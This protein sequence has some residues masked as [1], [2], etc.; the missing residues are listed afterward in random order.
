MSRTHLFIFY[1]TG[2]HHEAESAKGSFPALIGEYLAE[3]DGYKIKFINGIGTEEPEPE[4]SLSGSWLSLTTLFAVAVFFFYNL[5]AKV[6][7]RGLDVIIQR[8]WLSTGSMEQGDKCILMG[9]S[10]GGFSA[11]MLAQYIHINGFCNAC[12]LHELAAATTTVSLEKDNRQI[13][14]LYALDPVG[15]HGFRNA[16][17]ALAQLSS[18]T[19]ATFKINTRILNATDPPMNVKHVHV[20]LMLDECRPPFEP[21]IY[22]I[23]TTT[24]TNLAP[25]IEQVWFKGVHADA[26]GPSRNTIH[27]LAYILASFHMQGIDINVKNL[28]DARQLQEW[29]NAPVSRPYPWA[30]HLLSIVGHSRT[31]IH[32]PGTSLHASAII[33]GETGQIRHIT[34]KEE[35]FLTEINNLLH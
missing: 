10:R 12:T 30:G 21:N 2:D 5:F 20:V 14:A 17:L 18:A 23:A 35:V 27:I 6:T 26:W 7:G 24:N 22:K 11:Q 19:P 29:Q 4:R 28:F 1:G 33:Q 9:C 13:E 34:E 8:A 15:S 25:N 3:E 32:A 31:A 16:M